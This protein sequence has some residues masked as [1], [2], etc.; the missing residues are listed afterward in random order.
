MKTFISIMA[1]I[2]I[3]FQTSAQNTPKQLSETP[4][5]QEKHLYACPMHPDAAND[6]PGSC[7][8]CHMKLVI[9]KLQ[10]YK[11]HETEKTQVVYS[12]P[13]HPEVKSTMAGTCSQCNMALVKTELKNY[14]GHT[15]QETSYVCPMHP[16]MKSDQPGKCLACNMAMV[17]KET[18]S[19]T[20]KNVKDY[21]GHT[22]N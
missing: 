19:P 4:F 6:E 17:E 10:N 5:M 20:K 22:R 8:T 21:K 7:S 12:C 9:Q 18:S 3:A 13:M 16:E 11:G 2:F 1:I 15:G 14:K